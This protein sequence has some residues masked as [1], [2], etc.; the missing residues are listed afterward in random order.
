MR[1]TFFRIHI[2]LF[3]FLLSTGRVFSA[4]VVDTPLGAAFLKLFPE[5]SKGYIDLNSNGSLDRLEDMDELP[6]ESMVQDGILQV[7]EILDFI[8]SRYRFF[9]V[10]KLE[11][12]EG[13]LKNARGQIDE[14][15]ALS[16]RG[17]L[18]EIIEKKREFGSDDLYLTPS[19]LRRAHE[20]M[21]GYIATMLYSYRK[22]ERQFVESFAEAQESLFSM[23]EAGYPLPPMSTENRNLLISAMVHTTLTEADKNPQRVRAAV[24]A[25]GRLKAESSIPYLRELLNS[26]PYKVSAAAALGEIGNTEARSILMESLRASEPGEFQ[27]ALIRAVGKI[28]GEEGE[29]Y[30]LAMLEDLQKQKNSEDTAQAGPSAESPADPAGES[31]SA[32]VERTVVRALADMALQGSR[33]RQVYAVLTAYLKDPDPQMRKLAVEGTAVFGIRLAGTE[34]LPMLKEEKNEQVRISL[35]RSLNSLNDATTLPAFIG[36]L[37]D[38]AISS[39]LR[40]EII[41]AIG[42]NDNG[43]RSVISIMDYLGS[44]DQQLREVTREAILRLYA[45]DPQTV[46]GALSRG[47]LQS[48]ERLFLEEASG[49][50]A[51]IADPSSLASLLKLLEKPYPQVKENVTWAFYRIRP[52]DNPR[53]AQELQKLVTSETE[54]LTVRTNAVRALGAMGI[55]NPQLEVH[56]TLLTTLKLNSPEYLMLKYFAVLSLGRIPTRDPE[57]VKALLELQTPREN[58]LIREAALHALR[59]MGEGSAKTLDSV[60]GAA[61]RSGKPRLMLEAVR[62]LGDMGSETTPALAAEVLKAFPGQEVELEVVYALARVKSE[63]AIEMMIDTAAGSEQP[64]FILGLL[65]ESPP[66]LLRIVVQQRLKTEENAEVKALLEDLAAELDSGY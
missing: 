19:A 15:I 40:S 26:D 39:T 42:S 1:K 17:R 29:A 7:Q 64:D 62:L 32:L 57:V 38:P 30:L 58:Q 49:I 3:L 6:S 65:R 5:L 48:E 45:K 28:G 22:E 63:E 43:P 53:V 12:V 44:R 13:A 25:L 4:E 11:E 16:Y 60:A 52:T 37:Q 47:L 31:P 21:S 59:Q 2:L 46:T 54:T 55:N 18:A 41:T 9:R 10:E 33:N 51:D 23:I 24:G 50:L 20:E 8:I 56:K 14:L 34:L 36:L 66:D 61:L 27:N 35:V